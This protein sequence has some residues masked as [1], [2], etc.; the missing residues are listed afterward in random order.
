MTKNRQHCRQKIQLEKD[1]E[2][3]FVWSKENRLTFNFDNLKN[4]HFSLRK[5][6]NKQILRLLNSGTITQ[7]THFKDLGIFF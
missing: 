1:I 7:E 4:V 3:A 5:N 2:N 6:Q